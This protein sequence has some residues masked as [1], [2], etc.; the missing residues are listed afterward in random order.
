MIS[1]I[2]RPAGLGTKG[3]VATLGGEQAICEDGLFT[4]RD[5]L[6]TLGDGATGGEFVLWGC[7]AFSKI[8][9]SWCRAWAWSV[10]SCAKG[11]AGAGCWSAWMRSRAAKIAA[12]ED[13]VVGMVSSCRNNSMV[14]VM[15]VADVVV[16][17]T[18]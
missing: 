8:A 12:S 1:S 16:T 6:A 17:Y 7:I 13:E 10:P 14:S 2:I 4:L 5:G 3:V 15:R 18:V 9:A 11:A